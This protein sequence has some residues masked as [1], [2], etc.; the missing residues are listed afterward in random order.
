MED[1]NLFEEMATPEADVK[2]V[3]TQE[4]AGQE[5]VVSTTDTP[6]VAETP[7]F[8]FKT[9]VNHEE[10]EKEY[11]ETEIVEALQKKANYD[12]IVQKNTELDTDVKWLLKR[13]KQSGYT[14]LKEYKQ[15]VEQSDIQIAVQKLMEE[16]EGISV[17]VAAEVV[18]ARMPKEVEE[19][20]KEDNSAEYDKFLSK[21]PNIDVNSIP[22]EVFINAQKDKLTLTESY[23]NYQLEEVKRTQSIVKKEAENTAKAPIKGTSLTAT[24]EIAKKDD[25]LS[26]FD[27]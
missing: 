1:D 17:E 13:A 24:Q 27:E 20:V 4:V 9:K 26:G 16:N 19:P 5:E 21:F 7:K 18:K 6:I 22:K 12:K 10:L 25:F 14:D 15:A 8:K 2:E 23:L 3:E 11:E